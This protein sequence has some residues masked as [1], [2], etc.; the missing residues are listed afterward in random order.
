MMPS[1]RTR[2]A[3]RRK[4]TSPSIP[5]LRN[6]SKRSMLCL[7]TVVLLVWVLV[8]IKDDAVVSSL[9]DRFFYTTSRY[10]TTCEWVLAHPDEERGPS[11]QPADRLS[12]NPYWGL[13]RRAVEDLVSDLLKTCHDNQLPLP[14][15]GL[16]LLPDL[17]D[18]LCTQY[19]WALDE[20]Q[21]VFPESAD[22]LS[23]A[24]NNA[25]SSALQDLIRFGM[26]LRRDDAH[27]WSATAGH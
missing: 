1:T 6:N 14:P 17:F 11:L 7:T 26:L 27:A 12:E 4:S 19:D 10:S 24:I 20:D 9:L 5:R 18:M 16:Q 8:A 25:R 23:E 3:S 2:R 22:W 21:R 15:D 13:C